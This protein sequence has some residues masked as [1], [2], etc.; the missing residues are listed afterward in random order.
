MEQCVVVVA[1]V[2]EIHDLLRFSDRDPVESV[3]GRCDR[4]QCDRRAPVRG[5]CDRVNR[6]SMLIVIDEALGEIKI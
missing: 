1:A 3:P 5:Q 4:P 2:A 6:D